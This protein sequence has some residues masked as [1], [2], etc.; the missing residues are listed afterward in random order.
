MKNFTKFSALL[1]A[2]ACLLVSFVS[3]NNSSDDD[4]DNAGGGVCCKTPRF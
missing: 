4:D 3:C 1:C 2:L